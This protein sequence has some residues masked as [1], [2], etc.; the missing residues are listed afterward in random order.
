MVDHVLV[1][2]AS[3]FIGANLS[4]LLVAS[5][6]DVH[7]VSR[8]VRKARD[9][10]WHRADLSSID[11]ARACVRRVSP[12]VVVHLASRVT[13][14][15]EVD[16]VESTLS[17]NLHGAVGVLLG[18]ADM[19]CRVVLAGSMEERGGHEGILRS[20]YAAAK[21]AATS[22]GQ[23][24]HA[25]YGVSVVN[26]RLF[27]VYGPGQR[28]ETKLV[29]YTIKSLLS[30][31]TPKLSSGSRNVDWVNV[32]DVVDA[33]LRAVRT[34][35]GDDGQ[36]IEIG[37]GTVVPVRRVVEEVAEH[38]ECDVPLDF[39]R[40]RDRQGEMEG[41]ARLE[42]ARDMLDWSPRTSLTDGLAATVA[43]YRAGIAEGRLAS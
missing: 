25:S 39:D 28:D 4:Q 11:A 40:S 43:W 26:L 20:P 2:G 6:V 9:I 24:V 27:M 13:G 22:Y 12:D 30:G 34:P 29:P 36:P 10:V 33:V 41:A 8:V 17:E 32:D 21:R 16:L 31:T 42:R 5:G 15:R 23:F 14:A 3:G 18:A 35:R 7:A 19:G 37:S 1:T 38:L